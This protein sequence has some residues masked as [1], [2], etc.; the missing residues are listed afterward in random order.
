[1]LSKNIQILKVGVRMQTVFDKEN[2]HYLLQMGWERDIRIYGIFVQFDIIDNKVW[3][4]YDGT[5]I[6]FAA[7]LVEMGIPKED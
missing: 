6:E 1:M 2:D 7:E 5:D 3:L 4:Q